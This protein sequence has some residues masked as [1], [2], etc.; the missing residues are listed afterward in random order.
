M[1]EVPMSPTACI[2][3]A[4]LMFALGVFTLLPVFSPRIGLRW[5]WGDFSDGPLFSRFAQT[6]MALMFWALAVGLGAQGFDIRP[7]RQHTM[8]I[9]GAAFALL[10]IAAVASSIANRKR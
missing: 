2:L 9:L 3:A 4:I 10:F 1:N 7:V 8:L 5:R 6:A